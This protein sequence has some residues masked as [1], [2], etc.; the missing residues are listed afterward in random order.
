MLGV[1]PGRT[2]RTQGGTHRTRAIVD[3]KLTAEDRGII[4]E[5]IRHQMQE[6]TKKIQSQLDNFRNSR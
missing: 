3:I 2:N 1:S 4:S 5:Q 6:E